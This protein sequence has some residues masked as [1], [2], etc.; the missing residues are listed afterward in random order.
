MTTL[1]AVE[2]CFAGFPA[3]RPGG[4]AIFDVEIFTATVHWD[5]VVAVACQTAEFGILVKGIAAGSV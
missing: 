2:F 3:R 5:V 4:I 1:V